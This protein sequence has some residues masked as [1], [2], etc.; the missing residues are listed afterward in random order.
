ME[1]VTGSESVGV[2]RYSVLYEAVGIVE[3][4][5]NPGQLPSAEQPPPSD[6][7]RN[8][9]WLFVSSIGVSV[10]KEGNERRAMAILFVGVILLLAFVALGMLTLFRFW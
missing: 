6:P 10:P 1:Q 8:L 5:G 2:P 7:R 9:F 4:M 3:L